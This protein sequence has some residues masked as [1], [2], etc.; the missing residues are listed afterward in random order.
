MLGNKVRKA[1]QKKDLTLTKPQENA[2]RP[3]LLQAG[4][5]R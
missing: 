3:M 4:D 1:V 5:P 2:R